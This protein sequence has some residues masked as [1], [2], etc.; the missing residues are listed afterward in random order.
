M[1]T[2][3]TPTNMVANNVEISL[4]FNPSIYGKG[5]IYLGSLTYDEFDLLENLKIINDI[6]VRYT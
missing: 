6:H 1:D 4:I 2:I 5:I 3:R